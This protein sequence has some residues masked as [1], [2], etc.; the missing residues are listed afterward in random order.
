MSR[1]KPLSFFILFIFKYI[2]FLEK[3]L[4][5]ELSKSWHKIKLILYL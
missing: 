2:F 5:M 1:L 4:F 3:R